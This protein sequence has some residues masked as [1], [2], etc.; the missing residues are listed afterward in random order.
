MVITQQKSKQTTFLLAV[1]T[2]VG[3]VAMDMYL[4]VLPAMAENLGVSAASVQL[5]ISTCLLGMA[6]GQPVVGRISDQIG[7]KKPLL[8][9][10]VLFAFTSL[11]CALVD[12]SAALIGLRFLQGFFSS[13]GFVI[14]QHRVVQF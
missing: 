10:M 5:T 11:L 2:M 9:G 3:P 6:L 7:R 1:M 14:A 13:V 8:I 12:S 4:P